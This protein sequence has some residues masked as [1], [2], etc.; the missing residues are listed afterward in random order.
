MELITNEISL[1]LKNF[2]KSS[3]STVKNLITEENKRINHVNIYHKDWGY[4]SCDDI[5]K[6][7]HN[8]Y[9]ID[10]NNIISLGFINSQINSHNQHFHIDYNGITETYFIPLIDLDDNNGT[11]YVEF[12]SKEYNINILDELIGI[13]DKFINKNQIIDYFTTKSIQ[14]SN[15]KFKILN[16]KN[17]SMVKMPYYL[18]HRG[19]S[20]K[21]TM[22]RIMFQIIISTSNA[23]NISNKVKI[24]DSELDE[25]QHIIDKLLNSRD[26]NE[27]KD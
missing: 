25:E 7:L 3:F 2:I 11:E 12:V 13:T 23:V 24:I 18:F 6:I 22:D 20:N 1:D 9:F 4:S 8:D 5:I 14:S 10:P 17:W 21:G 19:Q 27:K 15:Y 16:V 26:I